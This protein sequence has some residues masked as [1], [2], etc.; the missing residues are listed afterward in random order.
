VDF[1]LFSVLRLPQGP[2]SKTLRLI[3]TF[4][5]SGLIH[6]LMDLGFGVS[7]GQSGAL[8]FFCLH[9]LGIIFE[10][11]VRFTCHGMIKQVN[12]RWRLLVGYV[13][14]SVFFLWSAPVWLNPI[15]LRL[16]QEGQRLPSPFLMFKSS[17]IF[18]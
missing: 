4:F 7:A 16:Y 3:I 12:L 5:T 15:I 14:V 17:W 9:S 13:W 18:S 11:L 1:L 10:D 6:V 2:F 8:W